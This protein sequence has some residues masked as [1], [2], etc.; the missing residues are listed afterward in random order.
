MNKQELK[1]WL[2]EE[3]V[4]E[5]NYSLE[6]GLRNDTI[7]LDEFNGRWKVYYTERGVE[8]D[9]RY[10]HNES[11]ACDYFYQKFSKLL[12]RDIHKQLIKGYPP[13]RP[14]PL[15]E[16]EMEEIRRKYLWQ[17]DSK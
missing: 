13:Y 7:C 12:S 3:N 5:E 15:T 4:R 16:E 10:F 14:K 9:V 11:D 2:E 17:D 8:Y 1:K 6:G